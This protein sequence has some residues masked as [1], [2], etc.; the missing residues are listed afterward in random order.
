MPEQA[1]T[2]SHRTGRLNIGG[3]PSSKLSLSA[4][5][6]A[7]A[8]TAC[9]GEEEVAGSTTTTV[10][11]N[12]TSTIAVTTTIPDGTPTT[13]DPPS[14]PTTTAS[15]VSLGEELVLNPDFGLGDVTPTGWELVAEGSGQTVDYVAEAGDHHISFF[16][17]VVEDSPWPEARQVRE[18]P[19]TPH[20]D[21]LIS[22]ETRSVTEGRLYVAVG[23][24]DA[25]GDQIL[26]RGLGEPEVVSSDWVRVDG[27]IESPHEAETGYVILGLALRPE[28]TSAD[29]IFVD[30]N[31]V[32]VREILD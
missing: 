2:R 4:L 28:V 20:N 5:T 24:R 29:S 3:L 21:Y 30:V 8:L 11:D 1:E 23:F 31:S 13:V 32:S 25:D 22:V 17:P 14:S 15:S 12:P 6:I 19:V 10:D 16:A 7:L 9:S 26:E 18:F 27:E